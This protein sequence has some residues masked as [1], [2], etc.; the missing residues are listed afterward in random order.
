MDLNL[1]LDLDGVGKAAEVPFNPLLTPDFYF[2]VQDPI[3]VTITGTAE[4]PTSIEQVDIL[5]SNRGRGE[6]GN[7]FP[8]FNRTF[9]GK[10]VIDFIRTPGTGR[11][12]YTRNDTVSIANT[13]NWTM[14]TLFKT[15]LA[16][17]DG[18]C[19]FMGMQGGSNNFGWRYENF[20]GVGITFRHAG[21]TGNNKLPINAGAGDTL[22]HILMARRTGNLL[23]IGVDGVIQSCI[24]TPTNMVITNGYLFGKD[25]G[26]GG[27]DGLDGIIP[28]HRMFT[29]SLTNEEVLNHARN[30]AAAFPGE[31]VISW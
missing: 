26:A 14:L 15:D 16:T 22:P 20:G 6:S 7:S 8:L 23:E 11:K 25:E 9:A 5:G 1:S 18:Q 31:G 2:W 19:I 12:L 28:D 24:G 10:T 17:Q 3:N 29:R 27:R 4:A 21:V 13:T 30:M